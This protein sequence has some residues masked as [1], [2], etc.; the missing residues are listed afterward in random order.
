MKTL[1][2]TS[3]A[4][5]YDK[6]YQSKNYTQE[7]LFIKEHGQSNKT[8][9][10][11]YTLLDLACG[12]GTHAH[13]LEKY[14]QVTGIDLNPE[15]LE[16]AKTKTQHT[17]FH[18]G[19][20]QNIS[21]S[22][23]DKCF[24]VITCLFSAIN[25][26]TNLKELEQV[27]RE[28]YEHLNTNGVFIF[29]L[30]FCQENWME[31][32]VS[33]DTVVEDNLK[34][35]RLCQSHQKNGIFTADFVFLLKKDGE[36]NFDID[37]HKVGVYYTEQVNTLLENIGYKTNIYAGFTNKKYKGGE[38]NIPVFTATKKKGGTILKND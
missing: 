28:V 19:N 26:N 7:A 32:L 29:D 14:Y 16:I 5:C 38:F 31:G 12:T 15:M 20:M 6:I 24:D 13:E 21:S 22:I 4:E 36:I 27:F 34:L 18:T 25:Y 37:R 30:G 1:L 11:E 8:A 9:S 17:T 3:L 2:Y 35:A 33:I 23:G 10:D